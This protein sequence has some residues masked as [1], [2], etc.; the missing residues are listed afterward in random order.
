MIFASIPSPG[1]SQF[2]IGPLTFH[3][4]ALCIIVGVIVAV[5]LGKKRYVARGGAPTLVGDIAIVAVPAG[6]I[7]GRIYHVITSP[8]LYFG[9]KGDPLS[10][11]YIWKGGMGIWGAISLGFLAAYI[12]YSRSKSTRGI[13][14]ATFAD[15]IGPGILLAQAI[16]RVGNWFNRELYGKPFDGPWALDIPG[17]G[18]FHPVFLYESLWCFSVALILIKLRPLSKLAPGSIFALYVAMYCLGRGVIETIRIDDASLIFG[19]RLNVWTSVVV[20]CGAL[21]Y[22]IKRNRSRSAIE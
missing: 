3:Y 9:A 18:L 17:K 19:V 2:E 8:E 21:I 4:Y 22:L 16:G 1:S 15:A 6:I 13:P 11:L 20:G 14:F 10:A 5:S 12:A 7:G